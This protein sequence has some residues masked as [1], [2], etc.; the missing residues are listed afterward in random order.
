LADKAEI[1]DQDWLGSEQNPE[2]IIASPAV[3]RGRVYVVSMNSIYAIGPKLAPSGAPANP[4]STAKPSAP[5]LPAGVAAAVMV[6]PTEL[7]LK[8]GESI[9]LTARAYDAK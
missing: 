1:L 7:I 6:T 5:A 3:A 8:P 4:V 2:P 9:A